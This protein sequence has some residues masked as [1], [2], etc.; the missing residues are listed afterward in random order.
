MQ[1]FA[2]PYQMELLSASFIALLIAFQSLI[3]ELLFHHFRQLAE[4][5][6]N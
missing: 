3:N 5:L 1:S 2:K 6:L 4:H